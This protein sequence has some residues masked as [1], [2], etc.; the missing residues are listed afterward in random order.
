MER[1][2]AGWRMRYVDGVGA[3]T[4]CLFCNLARKGKDRERWIL[5]RAPRAYL[6]L[7]AFPYNSGHCMVA[8]TRHVESLARMSDAEWRDV[9][10]LISRAERALARA[11]KPDGMNV[12]INLGKSAGAGVIGHLHVHLVPRWHGDTN[13]MT[14]VG[15]AKVLPEDLSATYERLA[16]ALAALR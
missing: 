5:E 2:F 9:R 13:F 14:T 8:V 6:V 4:G 16:R 1:L 12:G 7:N 3:E 11:Y 10:L 15:D